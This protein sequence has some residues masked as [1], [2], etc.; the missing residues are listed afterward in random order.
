VVGALQRN[1]VTDVPAIPEDEEPFEHRQTAA[2]Q[3]VFNT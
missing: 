2:L 1:Q 3:H